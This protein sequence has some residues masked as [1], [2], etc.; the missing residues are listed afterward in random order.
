M[1]RRIAVFA[2]AW[3]EKNLSDA[4]EGVKKCAIEYDYDLFVFVSHAAPGMSED[5]QREEKRIYDLPE[6]EEFDGLIIFSS[7][8]NFSELVEAARDKAVKAGIPV[9]SVGSKID[10]A[11]FV[12]MSNL[13]SMCELTEHL[14][15]DHGV[16]DVE[17][18]AGP[19]GN[20]NSE[21]RIDAT[22]RVLEKYNAQINEAAISY[23]D[24]SV[25]GAMAAADEILERRKNNTP[26]AIICANDNLAMAT[27]VEIEKAGLKVPEDII[28]TGYDKIYEG[29]IFYPALCTVGQNDYEVG[30]RSFISMME[31]VNGKETSDVVISNEV[32]RNQSCGCDNPFVDTLRIDECKK[33]FYERVRTLEFGWSNNW[34]A[35]NIL[36]S[37]KMED[38]KKNLGD[39]LKRSCIFGNGTTYILMDGNADA[40]IAGI[41]D[42]DHK[43]GYTDELEVIVASEQHEYVIADK[44]NRRELIPGY[45]KI[46][47]VNKVY[48]FMPAHF[49]DWVFG[50]VVVENWLEGIEK[51]KIKIFEE[52]FNQALDKLK[53]N[54]VLDHL[55]ELLTDMY[56][57]D[58]LTE[59]YNRFGFNLEGNKLFNSCVEDN[60]NMI[61]MF[62]DINRMKLINDYYGHLQGDIAIKTVSGV[63][64]NSIKKEWIA[65]RFGGDEFLVIGRCDNEEDAQIVKNKITDDV[66]RIGKE[67]ELQFYLSVSCGYLY[68]KPDGNRSLDSYIKQADE[69][70]YEIKA[71]MH[72][73]DIE[74]RKFTEKC[75]NSPIH[76]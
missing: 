9:V 65:I 53:Q 30:C 50:Y 21:L 38:V 32:I 12:G 66:K 67:M 59:M 36:K 8:M 20:E 42:I 63:I 54:I 35:N 44:I 14:V 11:A 45:K 70:M 71:E 75:K 23:T 62:I 57:K 60:S 34:I 6:F 52:N 49:N 29:Q 76:K 64:K 47:G 31:L 18:I 7:T 72:K 39:Y 41:T 48:I 1:K 69:S 4:L 15:K 43:K 17:F 28:V 19:K 46:D 55:N 61:L 24:W 74:L 68:F 10:G 58:S 37:P 56:N 2:N 27:C 51:G 13:E 22:R 33:K 5:E 16:R 25:R 3:S 26:D 40:Y 73:N